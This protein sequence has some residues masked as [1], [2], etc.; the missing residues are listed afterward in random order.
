MT[1]MCSSVCILSA[2]VTVTCYCSFSQLFDIV[3]LQITV[4]CVW[5][6]RSCTDLGDNDLELAIIRGLNYNLPSGVLSFALLSRLYCYLRN[7]SFLR[8]FPSLPSHW[9]CQ[10]YTVPH[11]TTVCVMY[12]YWVPCYVSVNYIGCT[13]PLGYV[14]AVACVNDT[15]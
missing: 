10:L 6:N 3:M 2:V 9:K 5:N 7:V 1:T 14:A 12:R 15:H 11:D 8:M 13:C 4:F